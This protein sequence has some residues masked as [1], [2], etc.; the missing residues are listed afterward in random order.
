MKH[1]IVKSIIMSLNVI[2]LSACATTSKP[3][4]KEA[5]AIATA[6][7]NDRLGLAYLEQKDIARAKQKFLLALDEAPNIP[8]TWFS[9]AYFLEV[10]GEKEEAKTYYLKSVALAPKRGDV[11]NNYGTFLCRSGNYQESIQQFDLAAKDIN[12]VDTA[13]AYENAGSCALQIPNKKLAATYFN[14]A[15]LADPDRTFSTFELAQI[16]YELGNYQKSKL[17][18]EQYLALASPSKE[19][20]AL[21]DKI[22][23]KLGA[24]YAT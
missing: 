19:S 9:M 6:K 20:Y 12:Y 21:G 7:I 22:D 15:I 8:D 13:S 24:L 14:K 17:Y 16:T 11:H 10:T 5:K 3:N 23:A 1:P 18:L 4:E 2:L